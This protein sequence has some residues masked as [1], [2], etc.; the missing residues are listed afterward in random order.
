MKNILSNTIN[1]KVQLFLIHLLHEYMS[2]H[3]DVEVKNGAEKKYGK[4]FK[5]QQN[6][7]ISKQN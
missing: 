7:K 4:E 2:N 3:K 5:N 1:L 6:N